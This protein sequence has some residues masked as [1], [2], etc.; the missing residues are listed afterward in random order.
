MSPSIDLRVSLEMPARKRRVVIENSI[1][2]LHDA[3]RAE[4]LPC[5][6]DFENID[7][8]CSRSAGANRS[9]I[10]GIWLGLAEATRER[11]IH[12]DSTIPD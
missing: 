3:S 4:P 9:G 5:P 2:E 10:E 7:S 6:P 11:V 12:P 1:H 8:S